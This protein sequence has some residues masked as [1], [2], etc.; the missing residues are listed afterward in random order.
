MPYEAT[1]NGTVNHR[2]RIGAPAKINL[3]LEVTR[4]RADGFH[5]LETIFQTLE[6]H[7]R[8]E[9]TVDPSRDG[10]ALWCDDASLPSDSRNL[11]W[12]A[13][14]L[15]QQRRPSVGRVEIQLVKR[16]PHGAGLGG[17]SSDAAAVLRALQRSSMAPLASA[18]LADIALELGSDV[19]FFLLGGTAHGTGRGEV[20]TALPDLAA[21]PITLVQPPVACSTP[22]VFRSL[23]ESERGPREVRGAPWWAERRDPLA[24]SFNRLTAAAVR[25]LPEI[26]DVLQWIQAQGAPGMMTGSGSACVAFGE[27]PDPPSKWRFWRTRLRP[28]ARL[29]ADDA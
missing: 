16:I 15:W 17:G 26:A 23:T 20:L 2:L 19:P 12:R 21:Q 4:K 6:L 10:V 24:W 7:D 29:D 9:V 13:A 27:I 8:V 14:E 1:G 5:E 28:R 18:E 25:V 22:A 3:F 11:A